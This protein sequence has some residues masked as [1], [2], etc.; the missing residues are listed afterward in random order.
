MEVEFV[1]VA[2]EGVPDED[3]SVVLLD[4]EFVFV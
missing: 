1:G 4:E 3:G 2:S